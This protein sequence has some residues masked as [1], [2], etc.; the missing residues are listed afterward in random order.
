M[1]REVVHASAASRTSGVRG[2][3]GFLPPG[4]GQTRPRGG[5]VPRCPSSR[6]ASAFQSAP[7]APRRR[8]F[9]KVLVDRE[10]KPAARFSSL[11]EPMGMSSAVEKLL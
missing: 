2:V 5:S 10:G 7:T 11:Q 6:H 4:G 8:N 3:A 9:V 1:V